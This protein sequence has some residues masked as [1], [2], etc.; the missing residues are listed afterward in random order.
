VRWHP[1]GTLEFLGRLDHQLKIRGFRI[2]PGE[3]EAVLGQHPAVRTAVVSPREDI[4]GDRRL[5]AYVVPAGMPTDTGE[6]RRFLEQRLPEYMI[7]AAIVV[8]DSLP[9]TTNG[10]LDRRALPPPDST[11]V[12]GRADF[13]APHTPV[14]EILAS[15]WATVLRLERVGIRDNFFAIGGHSLLAT[16][17]VSRIRTAIGIELP[18]QALFEYPTIAD[19]ATRVGSELLT[20]SGPRGP[21]LARVPREAYRTEEPASLYPTENG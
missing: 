12:A 2:E 3:I 15:I 7:P 14:E 19:L 5:V 4:P 17:V 9:L 20:D 1:D 21:V 13:V 11:E 8:L 18:L 6:L 10:K 16:Q